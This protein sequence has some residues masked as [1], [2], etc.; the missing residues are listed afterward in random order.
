MTSPSRSVVRFEK[1]TT[2]RAVRWLDVVAPGL[3]QRLA[4]ERFFTPFRRRGTPDMHRFA[5]GDEGSSELTLWDAGDGR[6]VL[7][8]HGWSGNAAQMAGFVGPFT[9]AGYYVAAPDLPAHGTSPGR[10]TDIREIT[11]AILRVG[12]RVGPVHAIVA[13]SFGAPA[14]VA[15]MARGLRVES[16]VL[17]APAADLPAYAHS[18]AR[19]AGLSE[20]SARALL[21]RI[22]RRIGGVEAY[23]PVALAA[24]QRARLLVIHDPADREVPFAAGR[25]I[26]AAWP[27]A[28][29]EAVKAAGHTRMLTDPRVIAKTLSFIRGGEAVAART[30]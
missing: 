6:T 18:F 19:A 29:L 10:R 3:A 15:A 16:A 20:S 12:R 11:E 1:S 7:L 13:H 25:A 23:D 30:A 8:V 5:L 24:V 2:G 21:A 27:N 22:D 4:F 9:A 26:A 14:A 28:E 17:L